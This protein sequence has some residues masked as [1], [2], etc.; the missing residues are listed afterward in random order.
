MLINQMK[1]IATKQGNV[2]KLGLR[3]NVLSQF[4]GRTMFNFGILWNISFCCELIVNKLGLNFP[5]PFSSINKNDKSFPQLVIQI[6]L[7]LMED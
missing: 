6:N 7:S 4:D 2:D 3:E 1:P 5:T